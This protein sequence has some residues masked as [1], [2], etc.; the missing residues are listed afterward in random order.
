MTSARKP[1]GELTGRH[2][3]IIIIA[4][5][6]SVIFANSIFITLAVRSFP[7]E[8][9]KKSYL[10]GLAF[11]KRIAEREAQASLG[12]TAEISEASLKSGAVEVE[13]LFTSA[14]SAPISGLAV[15]GAL[16]RPADDGDDHKLDFEQ[17]GPGRY[18]AAIQDV[19]P[20]AWRLEAVALGAHDEK[21]ALQKRLTLE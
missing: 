10:Q 19:A 11:N 2:V 12:W 3:L 16:V 7:G 8:Q 14:S 1:I 21:F 18:R 5:F 13:L 9:E 20:G 6:M 4:F 17:T 15:T